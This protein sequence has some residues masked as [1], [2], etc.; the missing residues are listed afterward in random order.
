MSN[1]VILYQPGQFVGASKHLDSLHPH[2][3]FCR[4]IVDKSHQVVF[5]SLVS[6]QLTGYSAA[7]PA[8]SHD[9]GV[10]VRQVQAGALVIG[11]YGKARPADHNNRQYRIH[12]EDGTRIVNEPVYP[13]YGSKDKRCADRRR[14]DD[15]EQVTHPHVAP[16][17]R[18]QSKIVEHGQ[19]D[20]QNKWE[21]YQE[22][23]SIGIV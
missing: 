6:A 22:S 10:G 7:G 14:L 3:L 12:Y 15:V 20:E 4:V 13:V 23:P 5:Q 1:I 18:K 8:C 11:A 9:Q 2:S 16:P 21:R 19:F 17:T